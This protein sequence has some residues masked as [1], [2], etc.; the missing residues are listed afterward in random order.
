[1]SKI[2]APLVIEFRT[3]N[4]HKLEKITSGSFSRNWN[5]FCVSLSICFSAW[6]FCGL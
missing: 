2:E 6:N 5:V 1:M 4:C 3:N